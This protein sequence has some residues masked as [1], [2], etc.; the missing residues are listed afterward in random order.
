M[1][2]K[3]CQLQLSAHQKE[4]LRF[5]VEVE[6]GASVD[7]L[8]GGHHPGPVLDCVNCAQT[9]SS[10]LHRAIYTQFATS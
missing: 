7:L 3:V 8:E 4:V 9:T 1:L 6:D 2:T 10:N 5:D